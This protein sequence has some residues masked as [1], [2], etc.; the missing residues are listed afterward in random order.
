MEQTPP[1][2]DLEEWI[3]ECVEHLRSSDG[4]TVPEAQGNEFLLLFGLAARTVKYSDAYLLLT[5]SHFASQAPPLARAAL[6]HAVTLQWA[7]LVDGG[8]NRF[9]VEIAHDRLAHYSTLAAWM[10]N[11]EF[12][13]RVARLDPPPQGKRMPPFMNMLRELDEGRFLETSYHVLSQE[14]HVT[15][16]AVTSFLTPGESEPVSLVLD[17]E[18]PYRYPATYAVAAACMLARWV[19]ARMTNDAG[20]LEV[21]DKASDRL[22]LPMN[23]I[24]QLPP[25]RRR[26]GL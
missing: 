2:E 6:E 11:G 10:S 3:V 7:F 18:Y 13:A 16:A 20:L 24:E 19:V 23:L 12:S 4:F 26:T 9:R 21:L 1:I 17:Q 5:R 8:V 25:G 15:H 22:I 14:V